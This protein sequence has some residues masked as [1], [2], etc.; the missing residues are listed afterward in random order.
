MGLFFF[1]LFLIGM[2]IWLGAGVFEALFGHMAWW[3]DPVR[4]IR[5]ATMPEGARDPWPY[6]TGGLGVLTLISWAFFA[7][8]RRGGPLVMIALGVAT[9]LVAASYFYFTPSFAAIVNGA[10]R[11]SEA[12]IAAQSHLWIE[13]NLGRLGVALIALYLGMMGAQR[14]TPGG[15]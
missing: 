15:I 1:R 3:N 7:F 6:L 10:D 11:L 2:G 9:L 5:F 14:W 8:R 13:L 4:W 12:D